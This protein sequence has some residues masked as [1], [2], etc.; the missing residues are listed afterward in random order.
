MF[1]KQNYAFLLRIRSKLHS[2][3]F[4]LCKVCSKRCKPCRD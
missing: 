3:T 4:N 2:L 1:M